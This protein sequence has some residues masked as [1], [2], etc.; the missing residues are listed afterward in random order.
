MHKISI[1]QQLTASYFGTALT[2][3]WSGN[4]HIQV[5]LNISYLCICTIIV[6]PPEFLIINIAMHDITKWH[7][8]IVAID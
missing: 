6:M 2:I 8:F 4:L 3:Q 1:D 5:S 7:N